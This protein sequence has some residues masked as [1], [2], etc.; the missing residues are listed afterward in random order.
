V[1]PATT[2]CTRRN[3]QTGTE[4]PM[5]RFARWPT[6]TAGSSSR[7]T[8]TSATATC[9]NHSPQRLL[10]VATGNIS[11]RDLLALFSNNLETL[12]EAHS[13]ATFVELG[14]AGLVIHNDKS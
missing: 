4:R 11:N 12:V 7:R 2:L 8:A 6:K 9:L 5:L 14:S 13:E 3:F 1:Q 10:V